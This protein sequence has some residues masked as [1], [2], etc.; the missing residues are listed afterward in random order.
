MVSVNPELVTGKSSIVTIVNRMLDYKNLNKK[1]L[2]NLVL[3]NQLS[4]KTIRLESNGKPR[5]S[6]SF[7]QVN[8]I[9]MVEEEWKDSKIRKKFTET[10]FL[11]VVFQYVQIKEER[12][13]IFKGIKIW[14]MPQET[15]DADVKKLWKNTREILSKGVELKEKKVG[16]KIS[17]TNNLP[18]K[19]DNNVAHIRPKGKDGNDKVELPDG[20]MI[21]KQAYWLNNSY[22][23]TI[24]Q[25]IPDV[26]WSKAKQ[27]ESKSTFPAHKLN[28]LRNKLDNQ[29]YPVEE[30]IEKTKQIIPG[31]SQLDVTHNLVSALDFRL[32]NR[33]VISNHLKSLDQYI[34]D[35]IFRDAYFRVP[36]NPVFET[37]YVKRK[38]DNYENDFK[39]LQIEDELYITNNSL[40]EGGVKK[41]N[42]ISYKEH[43]ERFVKN[44]QFFTLRS[45]E[46]TQFSHE[47]EEY[48]FD[49]IFYESIL[50]RPGRL[51][52]VKLANKVVFVKS[53]KEV[54]ISD[55]T[56]Y[57]MGNDKSITVDSL[58]KRAKEMCKLV[59]NYDYAIRMM[60]NT[61]Y[62]YSEDLLKLFEDKEGYF[63]EIYK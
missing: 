29:V 13:L 4:L 45:L 47:L 26:K 9:E 40:L 51:K 38:I 53:K 48:G 11:F 36:K 32:D 28:L 59:I 15:L 55:L 41:Q 39:I 21:T 12:T 50:M 2:S 33:F 14:K 22:I 52:Y 7:E 42:L 60:K 10:V 34:N 46:E 20:Q 54:T 58:I 25:D 19:M 43:V 44:G 23:A 62:F 17:M 27:T 49:D 35:V 57:L 31:F 56:A 1:Q 5:E 24:L 30:F 37:T 6:M 3:P 61:T 18:K 16:N 8:F 63:T